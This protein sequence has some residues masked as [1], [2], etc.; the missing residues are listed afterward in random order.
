LFH[1]LSKAKNDMAPGEMDDETTQPNLALRAMDAVT[2]VTRTGAEIS[3]ALV[4]AVTRLTDALERARRP[5]RPLG[6][7]AAAT[8]EAPLSALFVAVLLGIAIGRRQ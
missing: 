7:L 1:R 4:D 5:H 2:D 8:R 6:M 3:A